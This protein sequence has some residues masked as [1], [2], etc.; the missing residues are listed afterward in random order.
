MLKAYHR[1]SGGREAIEAVVKKR[2]IV[3]ASE[4]LARSAIRKD[5]RAHPPNVLWDASAKAVVRLVERLTEPL[6]LKGQKETRFQCLDVIAG[7]LK[8]VFLSFSG[9][10]E[11][12]DEK[13]VPV[14]ERQQPL[15]PNGFV[16][17][18]EQL[19]AEGA[20]FRPGDL[21][22]FYRDVVREIS[23]EGYRGDVERRIERA[24]KEVVVTWQRGGHEAVEALVECGGEECPGE[25]VWEG[26]LPIGYAKEMWI[27][28]QGPF[29]VS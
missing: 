17:D 4:R 25:L 20:R 21:I 15:P 11:E 8:R 3:P 14:G 1:V 7:D 22:D 16:F 2:A 28:G 9:F 29:G 24:I 26:P 13:S 12:F 5:C 10:L 19:I 23:P 6:P 27:E 18:A